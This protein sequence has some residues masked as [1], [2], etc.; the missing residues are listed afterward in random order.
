MHFS[1][2]EINIQGSIQVKVNLEHL[3]HNVE[4]DSSLI[5]LINKIIM[6]MK[7]NQSKRGQIFYDLKAEIWGLFYK[8][9]YI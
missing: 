8:S 5:F 6:V 4:I 3:R 2:P 1:W 9:N 7:K